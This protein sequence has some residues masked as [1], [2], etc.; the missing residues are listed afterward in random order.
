MDTRTCHEFVGLFIAYIFSL[1]IHLLAGTL[2][3]CRY[4]VMDTPWSSTADSDVPMSVSNTIDSEYT[5][6]ILLRF[7]FL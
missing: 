6:S 3:R 5:R 2:C 4:V 7:F 1:V